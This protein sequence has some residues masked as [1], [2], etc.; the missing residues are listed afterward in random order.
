MNST[1][2]N[3]RIPRVGQFV[4]RIFILRSFM[5]FIFDSIHFSISLNPNSGFF[6]IVKRISFSQSNQSKKRML[7]FNCKSLSHA[8]KIR[9]AIWVNLIRKAFR[10]FTLKDFE[11][12]L[13]VSCTHTSAKPLILQKTTTDTQIQKKRK[14]S[15]K[16]LQG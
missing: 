3:S 9:T 8:E 16:H 4:Y 7:C 2:R 11:D 1:I 14:S 10:S 5:H 6:F 12:N 15:T 13:R